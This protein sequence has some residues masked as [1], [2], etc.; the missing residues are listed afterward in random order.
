MII[1]EQYNRE[2]FWRLLMDAK[3]GLGKESNF[4]FKYVPTDDK[5]N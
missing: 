4:D 1:H 3:T 5:T 2:K